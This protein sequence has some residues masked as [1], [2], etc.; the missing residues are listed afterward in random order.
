MR[1]SLALSLLIFAL[2]GLVAVEGALGQSG[3]NPAFSDSAARSV[4]LNHIQVVGSHNSY[5][6]AM[7]APL[8]A[9]LAKQDSAQARALDYAHPP[10]AEQLNQGVRSLEL[11][12]YYDPEG[13]RYA[14]PHG[15][16]TIRQRGSAPLPF[17]PEGLM[18]APG[19]KVLHI[20]G[21][22]FRS[23]C[24]TL[25]R[26]LATIRRWSEAHPEHV[27]LIIT[28]NAKDGV[29]DRPGFAEPLPFDAAAFDALDAAFRQG[30]GT[31]RLLTPDAVRGRHASLEEAALNGGWPSLDAS[32]GRVL[33]VLD[34]R[35]EKL[36]RYRAGHPSLQGRAL[37]GN[38]EEGTPEA[39]FRIINDPVERGDD[40]KRLVRK[41]YM[42]RTRADA[43]T[44]E[45]RQ[46][47]T[48]RREAAFASGAHVVTTDYYRPD[49]ALGTGY[50]VTLPEGGVARCNPV[51]A[52][53]GCTSVDE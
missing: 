25:Q 48:Q 21:L 51:A 46:G 38:Y 22:D 23:H 11:D 41:G 20:Q 13:G 26:C 53:P 15:L 18:E 35:G 9:M 8:M 7:D 34:E 2:A 45:A 19:F 28:V 44:V 33:V 49:P 14:Q 17:D 24:L 52:G 5:K 37:F 3:L 40:I 50:V 6:R 39:A 30:L 47:T 1:H 36:A 16:Q 12:V 4:R 27:P 43:N 42:V 31:G 32:R 29:I 10:L